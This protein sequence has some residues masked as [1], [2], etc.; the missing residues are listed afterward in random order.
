MTIVRDFPCILMYGRSSYD[1]AHMSAMHVL[2]AKGRTP[3]FAPSRSDRTKRS[4]PPPALLSP[5]YRRRHYSPLIARLPGV[6]CS[7]LRTHRHIA[8]HTARA[9]FGLQIRLYH[10][11]AS[12]YPSFACT[13][14]SPCD[15]PEPR[16]VN[17]EQVTVRRAQGDQ[18]KVE[19]KASASP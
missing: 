12:M 2:H 6:A 5:V 17:P 19:D 7:E 1:C 13:G 16:T 8:C 10:L 4:S 9:N 3:S 11:L 15:V 14:S 18:S